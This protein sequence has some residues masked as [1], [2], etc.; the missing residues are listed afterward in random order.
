M[1]YKKSD[2]NEWK[3]EVKQLWKDVSNRAAISTRK[4]K[5]ELI[6]IHLPSEESFSDL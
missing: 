4:L 1:K 3:Y 2:E 5:E 6:N